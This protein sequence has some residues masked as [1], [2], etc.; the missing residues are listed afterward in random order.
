MRKQVSNGGIHGDLPNGTTDYLHDGAR[1]V[2]ERDGTGSV[3]RQHVWGR[4]V[5]ELIQKRET[6][7]GDYY[8][9]ADAQH[10]AAALTDGSGNIT[11]A[12]DADAY[13][14]TLAFT[15]G[16]GLLNAHSDA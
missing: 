5:D 14:R 16:P 15:A 13:G 10:R 8:P 2:E 6:G 3:L 12:Y 1:C 9:L 11:E 4:Y 7:G